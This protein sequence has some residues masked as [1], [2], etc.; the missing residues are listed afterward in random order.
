[1][2]KIF[3][4]LMTVITLSG[5]SIVYAD[6]TQTLDTLSE[7]KIH[8]DNKNLTILSVKTVNILSEE[9]INKKR[10]DSIDYIKTLT[11]TETQKNEAIEELK[12]NKKLSGFEELKTKYTKISEDNIAKEKEKQKREQE[13]NGPVTF[14]ADGTLE[15]QKSDAAQEV[16]N[17]L[18]SI[19]DH[20]N[21]KDYHIAHGIDEKIDNLTIKECVYV[22]KRIEDP[23]FGQTGDG[24]EGQENATSHK[25]F[26]ENQ[27]NNRFGGSIKNLLKQWGTFKYPGY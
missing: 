14:N 6:D 9:D 1:M 19:P 25:A 11:L 21:G 13:L 7:Q 16:I 24:Y 10:D 22:M 23:G 4:L 3:T 15:Y 20:K 18:L 27:L 12:T 17:L 8:Q 2:K 26:V 5:S